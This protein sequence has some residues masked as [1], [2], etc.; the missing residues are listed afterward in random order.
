MSIPLQ[1]A[2]TNCYMFSIDKFVF[3][4]TLLFLDLISFNCHIL[5]TY[6]HFLCK[7]SSIFITFNL[8]FL[9]CNYMVTGQP[10]LGQLPPEQ[11]PWGQLP[12]GQ[13]PHGTITQ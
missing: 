3:K 5:N 12:Q 1:T 11:L 13:L 10:P 2:N 4:Q 6:E 9:I 7:I 8:L